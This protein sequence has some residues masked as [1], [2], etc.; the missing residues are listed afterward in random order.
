MEKEEVS[1][2]DVADGV[3]EENGEEGI[4]GFSD[5]WEKGGSNVD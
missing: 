3:V 1:D 4:D 2:G 5:V